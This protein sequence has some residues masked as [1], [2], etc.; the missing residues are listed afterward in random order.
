MK[1]N[2]ARR[3]RRRELAMG[4]IVPFPPDDGDAERTVSD[5]FKGEDAPDGIVVESLDEV[6]DEEDVERD[7]QPEEDLLAEAVKEATTHLRAIKKLTGLANVRA[8]LPPAHL[9][10]EK[11]VW[12]TP[13]VRALVLQCGF[14]PPP[15]VQRI[16][17]L[18][19]IEEFRLEREGD[20][21]SGCGAPT[22]RPPCRRQPQRRGR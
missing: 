6:I 13:R 5:E 12:T 10:E 2:P 18:E 20:R 16:R 1:M 14:A 8:A 3:K 15:G 7:A 22:R 9:L 19:W 17:I 11:T 4:P 21:G